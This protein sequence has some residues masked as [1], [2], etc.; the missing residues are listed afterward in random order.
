MT[1]EALIEKAMKGNVGL[2]KKKW[3]EQ[4]EAIRDLTTGPK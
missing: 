2:A 3:Q 4:L 1:T